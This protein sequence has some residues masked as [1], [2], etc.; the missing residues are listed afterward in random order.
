[1]ISDINVF[2][3]SMKLSVFCENDYALIILKDHDDLKIRIVKSQKL[4][5]KVFQSN[6]FLNNLRLINIFYL[7]SEQY[8]NDLTFI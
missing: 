8:H 4:I 5:E 1:M 7:I 3:A 2:D 6:N